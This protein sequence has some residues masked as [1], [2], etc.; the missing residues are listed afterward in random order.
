M[1]SRRSAG[2]V[3]CLIATAL[4]LAATVLP[5]MAERRASTPAPGDTVSFA[6]GTISV[7]FDDRAFAVSR[8]DIMNWVRTSARAA[9]AYFGRFPVPQARIRFRPVRG[10]QVTMGAAGGRPSP[11]IVVSMGRAT[12]ARSLRRET[13]LVHEMIHLGVPDHDIRHLW[14]HEGIATYVEYVASAQ[15]GLL[16]SD[17]VWAEF[18]REMPVGLPGARDSGGLDG[19]S[20]ET[21]RYWGG[22]MFCLIADIEIRK[23][24]GN[25]LGFQDT[26]RAMQRQGGNLSRM[27][28]LERTFAVADAATGTTVLSDLYRS[29]GPRP[30]APD[31]ARL[32][33]NLG[34][35]GDGF[36]VSLDDD[37]PFA[38]I[39]RAI[40]NRPSEP[41]LVAQ[42]RLVNSAASA[43]RA[44]AW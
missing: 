39:R 16:P 14:L 21:R 26:L 18:M 15:A 30:Y 36:R 34:V 12:T 8:S 2:Q 13:L 25:R 6:G 37:A 24:T 4:W 27:W 38:A 40:T 35:A 22:A 31:L 17:R 29:M 42:P 10:D 20:S 1:C 32:W 44:S 5:A 23:A 43:L 9:T 3:V 11:H 33:R 41:L 19:T 7:D 28:S